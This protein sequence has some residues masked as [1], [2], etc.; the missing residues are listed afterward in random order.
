ME[1]KRTCLLIGAFLLFLSLL[2]A[3]N[4]DVTDTQSQS[5]QNNNGQSENNVDTEDK[6]VKKQFSTEDTTIKVATPWGEEAFNGRIGD[7]AS[8]NLPH[9]TI[10]HVD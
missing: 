5:E 1:A 10:E 7:F 8:E 6:E 9:I 4:S 2:V 3:C